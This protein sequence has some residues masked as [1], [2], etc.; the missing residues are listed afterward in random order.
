M[1]VLD[2]RDIEILAELQ[3]DSR[4]SVQQLA[5][6]RRPVGDAVLEARQGH[7]GGRRDPRLRRVDRPRERRPALCVLAE[8]NLSQHTEAQV[9]EFE[10]A[11]AACP[12][13]IS[14]YSTTGGADYSIKVLATDIKAYE[15]F[16][17]DT[18][19]RLP[20]V[21]HI[22]SS[23]VLKEIKADASLPIARR[24]ARRG[25]RARRASGLDELEDELVLRLRRLGRLAV[26][27]VGRVAQELARRGEPE[28]RRLDLA[29]H[30][31]LFDAM[32]RADSEMPVPGRP[33]WS[34]TT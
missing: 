19:F 29:P 33:E 7:G 1:Y 23:V 32:Q 12:Q 17:H 16:L 13:I 8:V 10:R 31:R 15:A 4:Q 3:R 27:R 30:E 18:A 28:A 22:R 34:A 21:T 5:A 20:G 11:V 9:R 6:S 26:A 14:C 25:R 24:R 2:R